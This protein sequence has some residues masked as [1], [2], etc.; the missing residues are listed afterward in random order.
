MPV[1]GGAAY[2]AQAVGWSIVVA[3]SCPTLALPKPFADRTL[4]QHSRREPLSK[5]RTFRE[6]CNQLLVYFSYNR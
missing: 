3:L 4:S 2:A 6:F 5:G 1:A